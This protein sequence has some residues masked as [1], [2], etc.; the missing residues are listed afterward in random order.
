MEVYRV[1]KNSIY[2]EPVILTEYEK[3]PIDCV[4]IRPPDSLYCAKWTGE[5]WIEDMPQEEIEELN[6]P[7]INKNN[8]IQ[9]L[10]D[11]ALD[12]DYRLVLEEY[13]I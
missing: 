8:D 7:N 11:Y 1:D 6:K 4:K 5:E 10:S 9:L 12:L 3:I 13:G 2:V